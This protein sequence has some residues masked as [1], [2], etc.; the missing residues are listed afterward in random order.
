MNTQQLQTLKTAI[1]ADQ[2]LAAIGRNDTEMARVLN[3]P[4]A[5][6]VWRTQVNQDEIMQNGFDWVRV[7]NLSIGKARIWEW[8]FDN[9]QRSINPSKA[10]V[11]AGIDEAWKG[12]AADLAVRAAV[13]VHCKRPATRAEQILGSGTGTDATPGLLTFE[14]SVS[15]NDIGEMWNLG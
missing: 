12:T 10:N 15:I 8:L 3:L 11:R 7:D 9:D 1:L 13:Y 14:G 6:V 5:F 2:E 4:T